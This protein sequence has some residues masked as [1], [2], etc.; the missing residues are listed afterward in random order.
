MISIVVG[1]TALR[2]FINSRYFRKGLGLVSTIIDKS[3]RRIPNKDDLFA[4][5]YNTRYKTTIYGQGNVGD[6]RFYLD[7]YITDSTFVVYVG[8]NYEEFIFDID[9]ELI[10]EKGIE[11]YIGHIL[12]DVDIRYKDKQEKD[13]L[14]KNVTKPAGDPNAVFNNPGN[15]SYE[16]LKA[17]L[18]KKQKE[19][20][21]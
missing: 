18:D 11:F 1:N 8:D 3:G 17:Y 16:D 12:K 2:N 13:E 10:K 9:Y 6:I 19:R 21:K 7:H 20:Y 14:T 4:Y 5:F 15:V